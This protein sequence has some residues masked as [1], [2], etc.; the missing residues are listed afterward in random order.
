LS[1][2][3][4]VSHTGNHPQEELA[5]FGYRSKRKVKKNLK[6]PF[7]CWLT[8]SNLLLSKYVDFRFLFLFLFSW[9]NFGAFF[10]KQTPVYEFALEIFLG[11]QV[12]KKITPKKL[13]LIR[14]LFI[15]KIYLDRV[16]PFLLFSSLCKKYENS[17]SFIVSFG[18]VISVFFSG[19]F[20]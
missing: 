17:C 18:V 16:K 12:T 4:S 6:N 15:I 20:C 19:N 7:I 14:E 3:Q 8:F 10:K 1:F 9:N 5:K 11:L 2:S 13:L